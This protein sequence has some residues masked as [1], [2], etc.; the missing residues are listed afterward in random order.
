[1]P[2]TRTNNARKTNF[3]RKRKVRS[4][5]DPYLALV[6]V[7]MVN[8]RIVRVRVN[9]SGMFVRMAVRQ[10]MSSSGAIMHPLR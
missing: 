7:P 10:R 5:A 3:F 8:V 9:E 6:V 2:A 4:E 1:M